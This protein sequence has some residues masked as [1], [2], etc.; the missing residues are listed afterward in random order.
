MKVSFLGVNSINLMQQKKIQLGG[1]QSAAQTPVQLKPQQVSMPYLVSF[2]ARIPEVKIH[3]NFKNVYGIPCFYCGKKMITPNHYYSLDWSNKPQ[4]HSLYSFLKSIKENSPKLTDEEKVFVSK[5]SAM[6]K[7]KANQSLEDI[8]KTTE[9]PN[10]EHFKKL[11]YKKLTPAEYSKKLIKNIKQF[12]DILPDVQKRV[13]KRME[14]SQKQ[15]PEATLQEI[16]ISLRPKYLKILIRRQKEMFKEINA[17][18]K[19]N[20]SAQS[21][22]KV[23]QLIER[24]KERVE[25]NSPNPFKKKDFIR[26]IYALAH[27]IPEKEAF[28]KIIEIASNFPSSNT[29]KSA[30]IVKYSGKAPIYSIEVDKTW[31]G[32]LSEGEKKVL[33]KFKKEISSQYPNVKL[34]QIMGDSYVE[35]LQGLHLKKDAIINQIRSKRDLISSEYMQKVYSVIQRCREQVDNGLYSSYEI[36]RNLFEQKEG[37]KKFGLR[38]LDGIINQEN[39]K[40][41]LRKAYDMPYP[42]NNEKALSLKILASGATLNK[43]ERSLSKN[44]VKGYPEELNEVELKDILEKSAYENS[45]KLKEEQHA[46]LN[47]LE[48]MA[49]AFS[50]KFSSD[51]DEIIKSIDAMYAGKNIPG[52]FEKRKVVKKAKDIHSPLQ[53]YSNSIV[54]IT[55]LSPSSENDIDAFIVKHGRF[56]PE[57]EKSILK[58]EQRSDEEIGQ[59]LL[60]QSLVTE[61]H[62]RAR[63]R[64]DNGDEEMSAPGNLALSHKNDNENK[65]DMPLWKELEANPKIKETAQKYIDAVIENIN[66]GKI[67]GHDTYPAELKKTVAYESRGEIILDISKLK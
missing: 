10:D 62:I 53:R 67:K 47:E 54:T 37:E 9:H 17:V 34:R 65:A 49:E 60:R 44:L 28:Q 33:A 16:L 2:S 45:Q 21:Q 20:L 48:K 36:R 63:A 18:A 56:I 1:K 4:L 25:L 35:H 15:N 66:N 22:K 57:S 19:E 41:L 29:S 40:M 43:N 11:I 14:K 26:D 12:E 30:F 23:S 50:E 31:E 32:S 7:K 39:Y 5:I 61:D 38:S 52:A 42:G 59:G 55:S 27:E 64:W 58:Y 6:Y 51:V 13:F 46:L 8:L 24:A 3:L